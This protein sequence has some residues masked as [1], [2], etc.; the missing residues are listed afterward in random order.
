MDSSGG[1]VVQLFGLGRKEALIASK[2]RSNDHMVL[3]VRQVRKSDPTTSKSLP[4][5][6]TQEAFPTTILAMSRGVADTS[7][8]IGCV[9]PAASIQSSSPACYVFPE[10]KLI[11][12]I[13]RRW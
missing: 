5:R 12:L 13:P 10:Q 7:R 3:H 1:G 2:P 8:V 6:E 4:Y 11:Q 9:L